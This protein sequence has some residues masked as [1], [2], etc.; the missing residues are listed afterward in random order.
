[1]AAEFSR[2]ELDG[3]DITS[4]EG[5]LRPEYRVV[6]LW[7]NNE[8]DK[9]AMAGMTD[10]EWMLY[11]MRLNDP[12][13]TDRFVIDEKNPDYI[14]GTDKC[15]YK[16]ETHRKLMHYLRYNRKSIFIFATVECIEPDLNI[17]DYA[18]TWNPDLECGD[19]IIH[20]F[21]YIYDVRRKT[22][23]SNDLTLEDA[24][25]M[26]GNGLGFCNFVYSHT[27]KFRD[28][29]FLLLSQYKRVDSLGRHRNNMG[30]QH[31]RNAANWYDLSIK[32]KEGYKFSIA[33]E[34]ANHKG[35]TSEK[36]IGSLQAHTVP[37]YWGDPAITDYINPKAFINCHD[38]D[39]IEEVI[40]RVKEIDND[41]EQWLDM[42]TQPWQTEEQRARTIHDA[43]EYIRRT[44]HIFSQDISKARRRSEGGWEKSY[45]RNFQGII[46]P[47]SVRMLLKLRQ[48]IGMIFPLDLKL[49]LKEK[50]HID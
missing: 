20:N 1:M 26:L 30:N 33:I 50:L 16:P 37:I 36:I 28:K 41:D 40:E 45:R 32:L 15:L 44:R 23:L 29:V 6:F 3:V 8:I 17:F 49:K 5:T 10:F 14:I 38:Y 19:R 35:Y 4:D 47:L 11:M 25:K 9:A 21:H 46:P 18:Y 43:E 31:T 2:K 7:D 39:T 27:E 42:V 24:R 12:E 22:P 13:L 34:N 48:T